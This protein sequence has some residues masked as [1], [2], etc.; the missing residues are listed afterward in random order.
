MTLD[1][2]YFD[3]PHRSYGMDHDRYDWSMI[4][5]R[6]PVSWPEGKKLAL[7]V[8]VGL[9][10]FP[11]NQEGKPFK[12]PGGM[13]M[14]YPDLRHYSLRD[15]GNRVGIYRFFKAFDKYGIK[16]TIAMNTRLA[17]RLPYLVD[18]V[19][20][21]GDEIIC[22]GYHMDALHYGGQDKDEEASIVKKALDGLRD[23]TGQPVRGWISPAKNES[24]NT[25]ELLAENGIEYF[26]DWVNDDMP[27][28][29]RTQSGNLTAMPL[30]TEI[31]DRF[32]IQN[33]LHSEDSYVEQVCDACDFLI[34]EAEQQ[35]GRILALNIHPWLLG[36]PHRI[37]KLEKALAYIMSKDEVWSA[38][39]GDILDSWKSAQ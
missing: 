20:E 28:A 7:W 24:E 2:D 18:K 13:T 32:V 14:P 21:R 8:N 31:E 16:P 11:L 38:S 6:K 39:A 5:D 34:A 33:N 15:Y 10:Y 22:H 9:Q 29:F 12:V 30:S 17:E 3:Y 25:P 4:T 36:Q 35:G 23:I 27:Y 19:K 26:C 1:K 37:G